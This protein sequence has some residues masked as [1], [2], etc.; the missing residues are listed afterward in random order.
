MLGH[1][2]AHIE[3]LHSQLAKIDSY[4]L[5]AMAPYAWARGLLQTIP[6]INR[7]GAAL[8]LIEIGD[9]MSRLGCAE[10]LASWA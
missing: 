6:G 2:H 3:T 4:L 8:I 1:I 10:R 5:D 9:N 7:I